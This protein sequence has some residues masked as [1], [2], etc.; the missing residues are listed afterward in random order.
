MP[1]CEPI[2]LLVWSAACLPGVHLPFF[3]AVADGLFAEYGLDVELVESAPGAERV[4]LLADGAGDFLLTAS[5]YHLQ[6]LALLGPTPVHAVGVLHRRNPVAALVRVDSGITSPADLG[7]RRLGAPVGAQ[8]G[9]LAVELQAWLD[10]AG[11]HPAEIADMDYPS[12]FAALGRGEI[13]AVADLADLLPIDR[14]RART[15]LRAVPVAPDVDLYTSAVLANDAVPA[16]LVDRFVR[17]AAASFDRQRADP[18]RGVPELVAMYP[19]VDPEAAAETWLALEPYAFA[20]GTGAVAS[21]DAQGWARTLDWLARA[22][23]VPAVP[24]D[25]VVRAERLRVASTTRS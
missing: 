11:V 3:A 14:R 6:A 20:G 15:P 7:G 2:R 10:A 19:E 8:M 9:W 4:K 23:G 12:A 5:L 25:Q 16:E 21:M 13:D 1:A 18:G 24:V 22:H 17:A